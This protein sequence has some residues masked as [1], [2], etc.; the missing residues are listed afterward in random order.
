MHSTDAFSPVAV[1]SSH[2]RVS[3]YWD[4]FKA[5]PANNQGYIERW[6][7]Y[8]DMF[9]AISLQNRVCIMLWDAASNRFVYAV[10]ETAVLCNDPESYT[11]PDGV[12]VSMS[13]FAGEHLQATLAMQKTAIEL[14]FSYPEF[15]KKIVM[16]QD[17]N[18]MRGSQLIHFL[19]QIMV[20]ETNGNNEPLLYLSFMYDITH[21]K[22][23]TSAGLVVTTPEET[24]IW[25]Y[26]FDKKK[27]ETVPPFTKKEASILR[28]LGEGKNTREIS[29]D[30][31][32]SPHTVD[33]HRRNLLSKTHCVDT[34]ALV[35][36]CRMVGLL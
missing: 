21:L 17:C 31:F 5:T 29:Q 4:R 14:C 6:L 27:L 25:H 16:S 12:H 8:G 28:M 33:T 3:R 18:Y 30:L 10:D 36:Y 7:S 11:K 9:R 2:E 19:Q 15:V 1:Y 23:S 34:T 35:T 13:R 24:F 26:N 20:V 32:I 22:K